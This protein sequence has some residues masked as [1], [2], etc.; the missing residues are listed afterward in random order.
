MSEPFIAEIRIFGG[1]FAIRGWATCDGQ[2]MSISQNT[3]LFSLLGIT[4][5]GNGTTTFALPNMGSRA[6]MAAGDG[7]GLTPRVLGEESGVDNVTLLI[8]EMPAHTHQMDGFGGFPDAATPSPTVGLGSFSNSIYNT[9]PDTTMNP[10]GLT[11]TGSTLP[12]NNLQPYLGLLFIIALNGI[13]PA[14]G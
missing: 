7:A 3:A 11:M 2:V 10:Q 9:S 4:Y 12:H 1:N 8:T 6:P 14:R 5:G 13:Y